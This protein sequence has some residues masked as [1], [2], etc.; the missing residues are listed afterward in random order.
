V[1]NKI[2]RRHLIERVAS[3]AMGIVSIIIGLASGYFLLVSPENIN[4]EYPIWIAFLA[5]L[6]FL[7]GGLLIFAH[8]FNHPTFNKIML[9]ALALCL[10]VIVNWAAFFTSHIQ[11]RV[12]ISFFDIP[13][14]EQYLSE[15]ES[16]AN[17]HIIM[18]CLDA[19]VLV[20]LIGFGWRRLASRDRESTK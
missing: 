4:P 3:I 12:T 10:L 17:L 16:R 19:V 20:V 2:I 1:I 9:S 11:G 13:I 14:L 6:V 8:A 7:F 18:A 5:P 15:V